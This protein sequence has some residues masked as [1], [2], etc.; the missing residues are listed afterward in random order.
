MKIEKIDSLKLD[1]QSCKLTL[2]KKIVKS[3]RSQVCS[4]KNC[5][6]GNEKKIEYTFTFPDRFVD[7]FGLNQH[8]DITITNKSSWVNCFINGNSM[9]SSANCDFFSQD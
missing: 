7:I 5:K 2:N 1:I 9:K 4:C 8:D 6:W 3:K